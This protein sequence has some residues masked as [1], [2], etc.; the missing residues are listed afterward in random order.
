MLSELQPVAAPSTVTVPLVLTWP[1]AAGTNIVLL[2]AITVTRAPWPK[3]DQLSGTSQGTW[4]AIID[5]GRSTTPPAEPGVVPL[6]FPPATR[7]SGFVLPDP[8]TVNG[9]TEQFRYP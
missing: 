8:G 2:G 6:A 9:L 5:P 4:V 1:F 7:S 3:I